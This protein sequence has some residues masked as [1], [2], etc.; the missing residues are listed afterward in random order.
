MA[1]STMAVRENTLKIQPWHEGY[2]VLE[3]AKNTG[4]I[5]KPFRDVRIFLSSFLFSSFKSVGA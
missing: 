4:K 3:S 1:G 2:N 5:R